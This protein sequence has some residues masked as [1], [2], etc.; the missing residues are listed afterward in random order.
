MAR[1]C[2]RGRGQN[3]TSDYP[4][5]AEW[6]VGC[7]L[8][9]LACFDCCLMSAVRLSARRWASIDQGEEPASVAGRVAVASLGCWPRPKSYKD[10]VRSQI[11]VSQPEL[12]SSSKETF[13]ASNSASQQARQSEAAIIIQQRLL[14]SLSFLSSSHY[15]TIY[16]L[17]FS[18][19]GH[20]VP[21]HGSCSWRSYR[22]KVESSPT[23]LR[24]SAGLLGLQHRDGPVHR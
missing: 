18:T 1:L 4:Q 7:S 23:R 17:L 9:L 11:L 24:E 2:V 14:P 16:S 22:D 6:S 19:L 20:H 12:N 10:Q 13:Q 21:L 5:S 15:E 8:C 3:T